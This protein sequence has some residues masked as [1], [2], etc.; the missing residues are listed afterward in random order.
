ML[1]LGEKEREGEKNKRDKHMEKKSTD[2][3]KVRNEKVKYRNANAQV[4][5][6]SRVHDVPTLLFV[7][8]CVVLLRHY[9]RTE[10]VENLYTVRGVSFIG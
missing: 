3:T 2:G 9:Y 6:T 8:S 7:L 4:S 5:H 1:A 10:Q